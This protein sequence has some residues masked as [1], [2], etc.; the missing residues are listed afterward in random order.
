MLTLSPARL[1]SS[2]SPH[3]VVI[4]GA[5][6][7]GLYAAKKLD[8]PSVEV[9]LIDKRNFHL[10]QPLLYQVATGVLSARDIS[11]PI[12]A[13]LNRHKNINVMMGKV[14]DIDT[15][16][17]RVRL[18][19]AQE[20]PYDSLIIATG[21][22]HQYFGNEQWSE[23]APGMKTIEDALEV[24]RR[25]LLVFE[26]LEHETDPATRQAL[27]TFVVVGGGPTGVELAGAL[28]ELAYGTLRND[29]RSLDT[30]E[31]RIILVQSQDR[32]LPNYSPQLSA[33]AEAALRKIGVVVQ[34]ET[35]VTDIDGHSVTLKHK[36]SNQSQQIE[37]QTI[38][39][40]AGVKASPI[41]KILAMRTQAPL[42]K[43][44]RVIVEPDFSLPNHSNIFVIGDLCHY[45]HQ[46]EGQPLPGIAPVAMQ[47]GRYV[48]SFI[49][50]KL[51]GKTSASFRYQDTG[52]LAVIG[53]NSAV[54]EYGMLKLSGFPAWMAWLFIHIYFLIEFD[55]KLVVVLQWA[56]NYF[57]WQRGNRLITELEKACRTSCRTNTPK[58]RPN[59]S[60]A[61]M[62]SAY[63]A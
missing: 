41:S 7:A 18:A 27:S 19:S 40:S 22:S 35:R 28:A 55:N 10:F 38:L 25:I 60:D 47:E 53:R 43:V 48:A 1:H 44:G 29:F 61:K 32:L 50:H 16:K 42:D 21:V 46:L 51:V 49:R 57:T 17:Q 26:A 4:V 3:R 54:I 63:Q 37:A 20:V 59:N 45:A 8:C 6:F 58:K 34:T 2:A 36:R 14:I 33:Q 12:R 62:P 15:E 30:S 24:R 39:W 13:I 23:I 52:R 31:I 9:T 11:S 5:G 56:W